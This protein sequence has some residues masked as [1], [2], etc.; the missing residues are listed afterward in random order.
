VNLCEEEMQRRSA[1]PAVDAISSLPN[2]ILSRILSLLSIKEAVATSILSKRW[3]HVWHFVDSIDFPDAIELMDS[4]SIIIFNNFMDSVLVSRDAAGSH[5]INTFRLNINYGNRN[6]AWNLGFP[7]V[8]KWIDLV[9]QG[10]LRYLC[11]DLYVY[12]DDDSD[13]SKIYENPPLPISIFSCR[14]LVSLDIARFRVKG[15]T[16]SGFPLLNVLHLA[17]FVFQQVRDFVLLLAG[18]PNLEYLRVQ[19]VGFYYQGDSP[20]IQEFESV[21]L[22]KLISAVITQ[23]RCFPLKAVSN[24]EYLSIETFMLFTED[25]KVYG[26]CFNFYIM[27]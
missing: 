14:T 7:N 16:F 20:T 3:I 9:V 2:S 4:Q 15:F 24:L 26:V 21:T 11:L 22:P 27:V 8:T 25:H 5:F 6:L 10:G 23:C 13:H 1:A 18:C 19:D 17:D 12:D